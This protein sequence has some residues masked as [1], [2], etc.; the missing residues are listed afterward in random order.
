[1]ID[2]IVRAGD[3]QAIPPGVAHE[4]EPRDGLRFLVEFLGPSFAR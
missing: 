3:T 4:V 1:M 2:V